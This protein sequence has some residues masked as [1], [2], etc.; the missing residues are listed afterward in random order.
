MEAADTGKLEE[1]LQWHRLSACAGRKEEDN[2][3]TWSSYIAGVGRGSRQPWRARRRAVVVGG[4]SGAATSGDGTRPR[5]A[6]RAGAD[7]WAGRAT[8]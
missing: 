4:G 1:R 7:R 5:R 6:L 3:A 8:V 2:G